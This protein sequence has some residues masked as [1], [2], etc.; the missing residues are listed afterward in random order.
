MLGA[1]V[2]A[3]SASVIRSSTLTAATW[4]GGCECDEEA[5]RGGSG[6]PCYS[7]GFLLV[8]DCEDGQTRMCNAGSWTGCA[9]TH[10]SPTP[11]GDEAAGR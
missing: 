9:E 2:V 10:D 6:G 7:N 8:A 1:I 4:C 11:C 3:A 5:I